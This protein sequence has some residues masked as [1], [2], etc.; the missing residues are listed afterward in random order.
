MNQ[1]SW[2]RL[3]DAVDVKFGIDKHGNLER[4]LED[5]PDL[6]EK[7]NFIEFNKG[8]ETFRLELVTRPAII[9]KKS[10]HGKAASAGVRFENIYDPD[11]LTSKVEVFRKSGDELIPVDLGDISLG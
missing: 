4:P 1:A 11:T 2:E 6:T 5:R 8:G 3:A 9:D 10:F 7:V